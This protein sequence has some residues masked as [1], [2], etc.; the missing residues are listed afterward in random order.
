MSLVKTSHVNDLLPITVFYVQD[1]LNMG[2][3]RELVAT[4]QAEYAQGMRYLVIDLT[5]CPLL[6]SAGV[7]GILEIYKLLNQ[8]NNSQLSNS[9]KLV[10]NSHLRLCNCSEIVQKVLDIAGLSPILGVFKN[11]EE[12][13]ASFK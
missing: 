1:C 12:A 5:E 3:Y 9:V 7:R 4:T 2:N 10:E 13:V 11:V 8:Q 6:S